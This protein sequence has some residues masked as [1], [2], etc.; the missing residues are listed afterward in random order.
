MNNN[1]IMIA[2]RCPACRSKRVTFAEDQNKIICLN[3]N[4]QASLDDIKDSDTCWVRYATIDASK[5]ENDMVNKI[6]IVIDMQNDFITG[7]LGTDEAVA[8]V[9]GVVDKVKE[10]LDD[11]NTYVIFT[12]D[13]HDSNY[14]STLEGKLLPV[15]HCKKN[16]EGWKLHIDIEKLLTGKEWSAVTKNTFGYSDWKDTI[17][18]IIDPLTELPEDVEF[19][20]CGLCTDICVVSNVLTLRALYPNNRIRLYSELCAGTTPERH[21]AALDVMRS[22]QIEII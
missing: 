14:L 4:N 21:E 16:T 6:L 3:C 7:S 20:V 13:T 9:P 12:Q 22:C 15:E 1:T 18:T 17:S 10:A 2:N 19:E 5:E 8:I 11:K